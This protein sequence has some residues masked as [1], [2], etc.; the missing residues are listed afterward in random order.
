MEPAPIQAAGI[1]GSLIN[2]VVSLLIGGLGIYV[3]AKVLTG[4][5]DFSKAVV[6]ALVG[7]IA[8]AIFGWIPIVGFLL[9]LVAYLAVVNY[10]YPGGWVNAVG[11]AL[12]AWLA[13]L[14]VLLVL[15]AL[16]V[17]AFDALGVPGV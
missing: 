6:T 11:I 13:S 15:G 1:V 9:A 12:V 7:A 10:Q 8:W 5:E 17:V 14:V 3:G 2:F 4:V 16:G